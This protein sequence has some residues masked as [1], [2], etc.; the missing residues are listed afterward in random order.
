M[1]Y[2]SLA[3]LLL[4][5]NNYLFGQKQ[6]ITAKIAIE[7]CSCIEVSTAIK[8]DSCLTS[9]MAKIISTT[10]NKAEVE[11]IG[12]VK[13]TAWSDPLSHCW[14]KSKATLITDYIEEVFECIYTVYKHLFYFY[15]KPLLLHR[16]KHNGKFTPIMNKTRCINRAHQLSTC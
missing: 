4:V 6:G 8:A 14:R 15:T 2:I 13:Q 11:F 7:A 12:T 3:I 1:K 16:Y 9:S 10:E 5:T